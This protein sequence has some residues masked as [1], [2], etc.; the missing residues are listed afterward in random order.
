MCWLWIFAGIP[1]GAL[2]LLAV[3][4]AVSAGRDSEA[5]RR[6]AARGEN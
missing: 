6:A 1:I 4:L 3:A 2:L 5:E